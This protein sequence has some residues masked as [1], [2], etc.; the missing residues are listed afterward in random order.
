MRQPE[1]SKASS[2]QRAVRLIANARLPQLRPPAHIRLRRG[3]VPYWD[4]IIDCRSRDEWRPIDLYLVA[5]LARTMADAE[6]EQQALAAESTVI[7]NKRGRLVKN[8]RLAVVDR[9]LLR[10]LSL[11]RGLRIATAAKSNDLAA[12]RAL[13]RSIEDAVRDDDGDGLLA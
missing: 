10:E 2:V 11:R 8:P 12:R 5:Q 1:R 9:L 3:D 7:T 6:A 4:A 13:E